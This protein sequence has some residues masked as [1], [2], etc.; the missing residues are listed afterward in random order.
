MNQHND[1]KQTP[2][3]GLLNFHDPK[4]N[5]P[6]GLFLSPYSPLNIMGD[7]PSFERITPRI[8]KDNSCNDRPASIGIRQSSA[9]GGNKGNNDRSAPTAQ[10]FPSN[11]TTPRRSPMSTNR[12]CYSN[13]F[14]ILFFKEMI[15]IFVFFCLSCSCIFMAHITIKRILFP[16]SFGF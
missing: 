10:P 6:S 14:D 9:Q 4:L 15:L 7:A 12:E 2:N 1:P 13:S 5:S 11:P 3:F 16:K 8:P